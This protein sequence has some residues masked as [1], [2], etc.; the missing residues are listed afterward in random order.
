MKHPRGTRS[1]RSQQVR[2]DVALAIA[3]MFL[4]AAAARTSAGEFINLGFEDANLSN[5]FGDAGH[6]RDLAPGWE[7]NIGGAGYTSDTLCYFDGPVLG[8]FGPGWASLLGVPN[9][10]NF[11]I[12]GR[13]GLFLAP[14]YDGLHFAATSIRESG[15]VPVGTK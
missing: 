14:A 9:P 13:Y 6:A 1:I 8:G 4:L 11:P 15:V 12:V 7:W 5:L 3:A 2:R 10:Y